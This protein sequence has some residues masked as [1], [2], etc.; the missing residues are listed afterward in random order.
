MI[1]HI[2]LI[3]A[4]ITASITL[5]GPLVV[6]FINSF[7]IHPIEKELSTN[8]SRVGRGVMRITLFTILVFVLF[9]FVFEFSKTQFE[10]Q[11][12]YIYVLMAAGIITVFSELFVSGMYYVY[13]VKQRLI[14][15]HSDSEW[16]IVRRKN[17]KA[18]FLSDEELRKDDQS[19]RF[20]EIEWSEMNGKI[21]R[22]DLIKPKELKFLSYFIRNYTIEF[23]FVF[24]S[25]FVISLVGI[26]YIKFNPLI[27]LT[28]FIFYLLLYFI[29]TYSFVTINNF[30]RYKNKINFKEYD[31]YLIEKF[32]RRKKTAK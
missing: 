1:E 21:I 11:D 5:I 23:Y 31:N 24:L 18:I 9:C 2:N 10:F 20:V 6:A 30:K 16:K 4:L 19:N 25:V 28:V 8:A 13:S 3:L 29:L 32:S 17:K 26:N 14:I 15:T 27:S 12:I 22:R 7:N